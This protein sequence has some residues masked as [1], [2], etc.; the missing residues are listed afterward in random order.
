M[1]LTPPL[2]E[3]NSDYKLTPKYLNNRMIRAIFGRMVWKSGFSGIHHIEHQ[4]YASFTK[5]TVEERK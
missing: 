5:Q 3:R 2:P 4:D 1:N